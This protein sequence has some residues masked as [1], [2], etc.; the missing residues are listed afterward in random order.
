MKMYVIHQLTC[1]P[2]VVTQAVI[3][4]T[5]SRGNHRLANATQDRSNR[6]EYVR[7]AL[8]NRCSMLFG[9]HKRVALVYGANVQ[10]GKYLFVFINRGGRYFTGHNSAK[11]ALL[12]V[13]LFVFQNDSIAQS[14]SL[15]KLLQPLQLEVPPLRGPLQAL[16]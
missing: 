5:A 4:I 13:H 1:G 10:K 11:N 16:P 14:L 3:P 12:R 6:T 7:T 9:N 8:I 2:A 15:L